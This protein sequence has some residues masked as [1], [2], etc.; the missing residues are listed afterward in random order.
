[1]LSPVKKLTIVLFSP[2]LMASLPKTCGSTFPPMPPKTQSAQPVP[3]VQPLPQATTTQP[4]DAGMPLA[5]SSNPQAVNQ[6]NQAAPSEGEQ[7]EDT[8]PESPKNEEPSTAEV[9]ITANDTGRSEVKKKPQPK[10][11]DK[12]NQKKV[13]QEDDQED[14]QEAKKKKPSFGKKVLNAINPLRKISK[15]FK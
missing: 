2:L 14:D 11:S 9:P 13:N 10:I 15:W 8:L 4:I 3:G 7:K 1:M 12:T 6:V 5:S